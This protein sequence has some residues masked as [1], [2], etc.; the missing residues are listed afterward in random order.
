MRFEPIVIPEFRHGVP[1]AL[2]HLGLAAPG[3]IP[4]FDGDGIVESLPEQTVIGLF[5]VRRRHVK[6]LQR[7]DDGFAG[8]IEQGFFVGTIV[9][10]E[11]FVHVSGAEMAAQHGKYPVFGFDLAAE[12]AAQ[13]RKAD[14]SFQ[15]MCF[16]VQMAGGFCHRI[17]RLI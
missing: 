6:I 4:L 5:F 15:Q 14:E 3:I 2:G 11:A 13:F 1:V 12:D 17:E 16:T 8:G 9:D 7:T 10:E